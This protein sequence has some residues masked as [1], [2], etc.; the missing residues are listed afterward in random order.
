MLSLEKTTK[1]LHKAKKKNLR[2]DSVRLQYWSTLL[3]C[4][5]T[6]KCVQL[7]N[8]YSA[9]LKIYHHD[10]HAGWSQCLWLRHLSCSFLWR[11][12]RFDNLWIKFTKKPFPRLAQ[13]RV[14]SLSHLAAGHQTKPGGQALLQLLWLWQ[15]LG[16]SWT[17]SPCCSSTWT[18]CTSS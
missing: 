5:E 8:M 4:L 18:P 17:W 14:L 1:L 13:S 9:T 6:T 7:Y 15:L 11:H 12:H 2:E 10:V 3:S 16:S